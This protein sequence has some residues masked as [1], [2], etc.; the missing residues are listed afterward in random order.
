M[1]PST[2][3][4]SARDVRKHPLTVP[5]S[6]T[7]YNLDMVMI[8]AMGPI[9][10]TLGLFRAVDAFSVTAIVRALHA[11]KTGIRASTAV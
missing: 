5:I 3:V 2:A 1:R 8:T 11:D 9:S 4:D 7:Q 6:M 10:T